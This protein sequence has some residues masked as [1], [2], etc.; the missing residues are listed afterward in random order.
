MQSEQAKSGSQGGRAVELGELPQ[1]GSVQ[2]PG[3]H[4]EWSLYHLVCGFSVEACC[5]SS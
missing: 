4:A 3:V 1:P 5:I 2:V